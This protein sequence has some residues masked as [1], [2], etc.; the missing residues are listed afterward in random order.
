[1][2][3][4]T[5]VAEC[6]EMEGIGA[7]GGI[8]FF[9]GGCT[10][11]VVYIPCIYSHA[12]WSYRRRFKS[13]LLCPLS[14]ERYYFPS[15]VCFGMHFVFSR[16]SSVYSTPLSSQWHVIL[17]WVWFLLVFWQIVY[18]PYSMTIAVDLPLRL[19]NHL[20]D[21]YVE[22]PVDAFCRPSAHANDIGCVKHAV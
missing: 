2:P 19:M 14:V 6:A 8:L 4:H 22:V 10:F 5:C 17:R 1:M 7:T 20:G 9:F 3:V 18:C 16:R 15:L 11:G 13:L 21:L 12:R